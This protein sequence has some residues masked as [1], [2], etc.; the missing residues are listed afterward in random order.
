MKLT[1]TNLWNSLLLTAVCLGFPTLAFSLDANLL[2][3]MTVKQ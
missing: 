1:M 3:E 2:E